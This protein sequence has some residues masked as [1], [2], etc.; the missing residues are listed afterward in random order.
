MP[1][2]TFFFVTKVF[3]SPLYEEPGRAKVALRLRCQCHTLMALQEFPYDAQTLAVTFASAEYEASDLELVPHP[4]SGGSADLALIEWDI[5]SLKATQKRNYIEIAEA[6]YSDLS[7][8]IVVQRKSGFYLT[9]IVLILASLSVLSLCT[10][11]IPVADIA[12]RLSVAMTLALT[13]VAFQFAM[14]ELLPRVPYLTSL[15]KYF[16]C[17]FLG[18]SG[19]AI[20]SALLR[21]TSVE[22]NFI[23]VESAIRLDHIFAAS[24]ALFSGLVTLWILIPPKRQ[25][26]SVEQNKGSKASSEGSKAS[27]EGSKASSAAQ[28]LQKKKGQSC[29]Q[30]SLT[31]NP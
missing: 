4:M 1:R 14:S 10:F 15:D 22:F 6:E 18:I 23:S 19:V 28:P 17:N 11:A 7:A 3:E 8:V 25:Q 30:S 21:W 13:V 20:E 24:F 26:E 2:L 9:R 29:V 27:S 5:V 31:H 12:D 16:V